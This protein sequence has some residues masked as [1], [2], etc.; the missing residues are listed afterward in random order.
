MNF[1]EADMHNAVVEVLREDLGRAY[2]DMQEIVGGMDRLPNAFYRRAA[3]RRSA[4]APRCFAIEQDADGVT[5]H[6]K[7]EAGPV[8]A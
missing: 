7:T 1:V 3:G 2:V 8:H 4:S 6:Y 5:V